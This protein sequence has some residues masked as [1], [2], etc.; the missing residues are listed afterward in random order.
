MQYKEYLTDKDIILFG[1]ARSCRAPVD[2]KDPVV[3]RVNNHHLWQ[4][5]QGHY[6]YSNISYFGSNLCGLVA[7]FM[8]NPPTG[9]E[10]VNQ[11]FGAR[12]TASFRTWSK[13][14]GIVFR[15]I[16]LEGEHPDLNKVVAA[17]FT[18][19]MAAWDLL[20]YPIKSLYLT[21]FDF[22]KDESH[23]AVNGHRGDHSLEDNRL[24][25]KEICNDKRVV[26]DAVLQDSLR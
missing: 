19:V 22:Y 11:V 18:G 8:N 21:G 17:P 6:S 7:E 26:A 25:M 9:I 24:A 15:A 20:K 13:S 3:V 10:F 12:V 4:E 5:S 2:L 1:G 16:E 23:K 14:K